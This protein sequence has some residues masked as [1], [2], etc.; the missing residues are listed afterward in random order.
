MLKAPT[1]NDWVTTASK[2]LAEI[3]IPSARLDAEIILA[4]AIKKDRTFLHAHYDEIIDYEQYKLAQ[5]NFKKR[6]KR[7]PIAY[8]T[9]E[10][11]FYGR[12]FKV[13]KNTLIPRPES[14]DIIT[15]LKSVTRH[16]EPKHTLKLIDVG[17]GSGCLGITAKL[18]LP[19]IHVTLIDISTKALDVAKNNATSLSADLETLQSN[20]LQKYHQKTDIILANLPYVDKKWDRSPETNHEPKF[21]LFADEKGLYLIKKLIQE[22]KNKLNLNGVMLIE[23]DPIQHAEIINYAQENCLKLID[24]LNYVLAFSKT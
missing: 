8:I 3:D 19:K 23:A 5:K 13:S 12:V 4:N 24:K 18:E 15:L 10:K 6:L 1:I 17:T 14:E 7:Q 22:S 20:L 11:E 2:K 9:G 21:A 16:I